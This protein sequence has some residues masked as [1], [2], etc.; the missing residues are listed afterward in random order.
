MHFPR[1]HLRA[2]CGVLSAAILAS[3]IGYLTHDFYDPPDKTIQ[4]RYSLSIQNTNNLP[5]ED[6]TIRVPGP[7]ARTEFQKCRKIK[8]DHI[9]QEIGNGIEN[10][11]LLFSW[12]VFPPF[13]TKVINIQGDIGTWETSQKANP[14]DF[15]RYLNPEPLIESDNSEIKTLAQQLRSVSVHDTLRKTYDWVCE[16]V[17]YIGY[18]KQGRG[19]LYAL[20]TGK[21]DCTEFACLFAALCRANGV[22][23]RVVGGFVCPDSAVLD[24]SDYHNWVEFFADGRWHLADPQRRQFM[25]AA[26]TYIAFDSGHALGSGHF[27]TVSGAVGNS[28]KIRL[29]K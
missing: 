28:L 5:I 14:S 11:F 16:K 1:K 2:I 24:L 19:A 17:Q 20:R 27:A 26:D 25:R 4:V 3:A 23:A 12:D 15:E 22:P 21:G 18:I 7:L 9:F 6:V 29:T 10:R 13:T 8:A